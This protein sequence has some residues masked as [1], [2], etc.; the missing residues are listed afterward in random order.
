MH[1]IQKTDLSGGQFP[2]NK[3]GANAAWWQVMVIIFNLVTLMRKL[4][5]PESLA[6]KRMKGLH[7][8]LT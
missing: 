2:S 8:H 6:K 7:F 3:F 1:S 4:V 5:L